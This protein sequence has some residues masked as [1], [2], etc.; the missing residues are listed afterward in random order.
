[1]GAPHVFTMSIATWKDGG[2]EIEVNRWDREIFGEG[3]KGGLLNKK[4]V[5]AIRLLLDYSNS[6]N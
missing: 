2:F 1:M 5:R 3:G 4:L 6:N